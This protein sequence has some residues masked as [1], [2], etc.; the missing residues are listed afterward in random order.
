[1]SIWTVPATAVELRGN[2]TED[3]LQGV[4]S[5]VYRQILGNAHVME[6]ERLTSAESALRNGDITVRQ[7]VAAV[8]MSNLYRQRFFEAS[9]QYRFIELNCKHF[10]G[11][12]PQDQAE[13]SEHVRRYNEEGYEADIASYVNSEEYTNSFGENTVPYARATQSQTGQ[14]NVT[15]NRSFAL[16]RGNSTSDSGRAARL[17]SDLGGNKATKITAPIAGGSALGNRSKRFRI[18]ATKPGAGPRYRRSQTSYDVAYNSL[19]TK[20]KSIQRSGGSVVSV[21]EIA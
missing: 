18:V 16:M 14:K 2:R 15:F 19:S 1:M 5:A 17:I 20:V 7:F 21:S 3:D 8:G 11:R 10:L 12:A 4:I 13:I 9:S 6:S